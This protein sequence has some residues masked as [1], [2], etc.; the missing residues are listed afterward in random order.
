M[1]RTALGPICSFGPLVAGTDF[2][3]ENF[4]QQFHGHTD[5]PGR[6]V[7]VTEMRER[8]LPHRTQLLHIAPMLTASFNSEYD[9]PIT[10][11]FLS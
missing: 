7:F 4:V 8:S 2:F 11:D 10:S 5:S 3:T 6:N 1:D 9:N